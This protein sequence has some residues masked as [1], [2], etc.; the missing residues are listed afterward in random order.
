MYI[1]ALKDTIIEEA[2]WYSWNR[3]D[4]ELDK[5]K[6]ALEEYD[7]YMKSER[8]LEENLMVILG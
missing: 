7:E 8:T 3:A 5:L 6:K 2:R 1:D 4:P